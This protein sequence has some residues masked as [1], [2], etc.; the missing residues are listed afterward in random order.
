MLLEQLTGPVGN[1]VKRA[2]DGSPSRKAVKVVSGGRQGG[3]ERSAEDFPA[4]GQVFQNRVPKFFGVG[5]VS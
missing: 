5:W 1:S 3:A 4:P 2:E